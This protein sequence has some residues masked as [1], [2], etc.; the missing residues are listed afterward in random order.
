MDNFIKSQTTG[1][2]TSEFANGINY[3]FY[4][5]NDGWVAVIEM[6]QYQGMI[7]KIQSKDREHALSYIAMIE[8][9]RVPMQ[10][11]C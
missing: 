1:E 2:Y 7:P 3:R 5:M 4:I 6:H 11:I 9:V 8:P 10:S